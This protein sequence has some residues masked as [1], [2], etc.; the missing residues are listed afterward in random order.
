M[1]YKFKSKAAGDLI[2]LEPTG[3]RILE[4]VGKAPESKGIILAQDMPCAITALQFAINKEEA[5]QTEGRAEAQFETTSLRHRAA[6]FIEM[7]RRCH[8]A[9]NEV[10]WGV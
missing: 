10:V 7:L 5:E 1:L 2:M 6:P 9:G 8:K 4:I 3:R